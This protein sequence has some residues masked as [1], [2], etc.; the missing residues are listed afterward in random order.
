M[1]LPGRLSIPTG[2]SVQG[3]TCW[4]EQY[5]RFASSILV[6]VRHRVAEERPSLRP[7]ILFGA[8]RRCPMHTYQSIN[9]ERTRFRTRDSPGLSQP[10]ALRYPNSECHQ[11]E[12]YAV[13]REA[14]GG[15]HKGQLFLICTVRDHDCD[16]D[17]HE[18]QVSQNTTGLNAS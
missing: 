9:L 1:E 16:P 11:R 10:V 18:S 5:V 4:I 12:V 14:G 13:R 15:S 8:M 6:L 17:H 3:L 7:R 2:A